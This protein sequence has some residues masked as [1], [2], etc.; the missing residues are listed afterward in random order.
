MIRLKNPD[1]TRIKRELERCNRALGQTEPLPLYRPSFGAQHFAIE[2]L[3]NSILCILGSPVEGVNTSQQL[4]RSGPETISQREEGVDFNDLPT[5]LN[6][7]DVTRADTAH[8]G[9]TFS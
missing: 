1:I 8:G 7:E 4:T 3:V 6:T 5:V 2:D 9:E